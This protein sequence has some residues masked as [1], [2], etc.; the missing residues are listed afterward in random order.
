[1]NS[2]KKLASIC[3]RQAK[4][5]GRTSPLVPILIPVFLLLQLR[6]QGRIPSGYIE[7]VRKMDSSSWFKEQNKGL[8]LTSPP[9]QKRVSI[10]IYSHLHMTLCS[11]LYHYL[12]F[13]HFRSNR[14]GL[15]PPPHLLCKVTFLPSLWILSS[16]TFLSYA[17]DPYIFSLSTVV[18]LA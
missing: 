9:T 11:G 2:C 5:L 8:T 14:I 12:S 6:N 4:G 18:S 7:G 13:R 10:K 16:T 3:W 15:L 1:M 17:S